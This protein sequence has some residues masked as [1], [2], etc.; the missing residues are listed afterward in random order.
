VGAG[1]PE[2]RFLAQAA[3]IEDMSSVGTGHL[4]LSLR[5]GRER[6]H[7]FGYGMGAEVERLGDTANVVGTLRPD[8][9]RGGDAVE[10]K[11]DALI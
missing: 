5:L 2:P 3:K 8:T 10:L 6:V 7:A 11:I 9:W 4:K 1:N